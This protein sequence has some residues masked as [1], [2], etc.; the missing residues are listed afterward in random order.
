MKNGV[1]SVYPEPETKG[2]Y[3]WV[4][5]SLGSVHARTKHSSKQMWL[6]TF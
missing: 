4:I 6:F 2:N 3:W 5:A 1:H